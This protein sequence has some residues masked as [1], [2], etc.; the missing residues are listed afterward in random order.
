MITIFG[1]TGKK[2]PIKDT[3]KKQ[4]PDNFNLYVEPFVGS[5]AIYLHMDLKDTPAV[6]NDLDKDLMKAWRAIKSGITIDENTYNFPSRENQEKYMNSK[7]TTNNEIFI[8]QLIKSLGTFG[9]KGMGK[10]YKPLSI[11]NFK[12]KVRNA[13]KQKDY[14]KNTKIFNNDYKSIIKKF[15]G[16]NTYF[17]LDP[18]YEK[19]EGMYSNF[20]MDFNELNNIL[21]NVKGK[22][23]L[24]LNDSPEIRKIFKNFKIFKIKVKGSGQD[25]GDSNNIGAGIRNELIIK[26]Y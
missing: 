9:S 25:Q 20:K 13:K 6:I 26:N 19:S 14:M 21:K 23:L 8:Q 4:S 7:K 2:S 1:R 18:P 24:T 10:I 11:D 5:G 22:F 17:F 12:N 3:I 15:D 16:V